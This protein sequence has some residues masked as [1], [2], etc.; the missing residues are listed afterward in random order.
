MGP[1]GLAGSL[2][3]MVTYTKSTIKTHWVMSMVQTGMASHPIIRMMDSQAGMLIQTQTN[4]GSAIV[5]TNVWDKTATKTV[6]IPI[7]TATI[8]YFTQTVPSITMTM[9]TT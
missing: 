9:W 6:G 4:N 5:K 2:I 8:M 1:M 7:L 3:Q